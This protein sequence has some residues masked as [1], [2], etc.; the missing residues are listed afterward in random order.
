VEEFSTT[1]LSRMQS[2]QEAAMQDTCRVLPYTTSTT[3]AYGLPVVTYPTSN[4]PIAC[5]VE[6]M[7]P[8]ET[9]AS[10][11]VPQID[12]R[13]RLPIG[14]SIDERDRIAILTRFGVDTTDETYEIVGPVRRGPSG[15]RLELKRVDDGSE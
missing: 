4:D 7:R 10:A 5:G 9:L 14:T 3:D 8:R 6:R 11:E 15:L 13:L 12:V 2:T 1:E